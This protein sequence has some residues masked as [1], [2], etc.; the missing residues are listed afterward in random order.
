MWI[1]FWESTPNHAK[2]PYTTMLLST[3][4]GLKEA[5]RGNIFRE[6]TCF[7]RLSR[8]ALSGFDR[9]KTHRKH[10]ARNDTAVH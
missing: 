2:P 10:M 4:C 7:P 6:P 1:P 3:V 9:K 8:L 5:N